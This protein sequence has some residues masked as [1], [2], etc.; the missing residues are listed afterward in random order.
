MIAAKSWLD[1]RVVVRRSPI[2]GL[3]VFALQAIGEGEVV[4]VLGGTLLTDV[5]VRERLALGERYDGVALDQDLN[6]SIE[7]GDWPG[8]HGNHS[9]DPNLWMRDAVTIQARR[10]IAA[11]EELTIDY[12]LHT[13][14][15]DWAMSCFCGSAQCRRVVRGTD[16]RSETLQRRYAGHFAPAVER[17]IH[18]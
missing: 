11:G 9:C 10:P 14:M 2:H 12:A 15:T 7:P 18:P 17:L 4:A 13:V 8:T 6:L 16:W 1:P 5:Q 3:G